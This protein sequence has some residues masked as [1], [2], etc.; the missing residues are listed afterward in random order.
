MTYC[1]LYKH[2]GHTTAVMFIDAQVEKIHS[3]ASFA[4]EQD[5]LEMIRILHAARVESG[6][7]ERL[8]LQLLFNQVRGI[9]KPDEKVTE[10]DCTLQAALSAQVRKANYENP[11]AA[12]QGHTV[13]KRNIESRNQKSGSQDIEKLTQLF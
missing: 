2:E 1:L 8:D 7:G 6:D 11:G 5:W 9:F 10:E 12:A 4:R 3:H 13:Q